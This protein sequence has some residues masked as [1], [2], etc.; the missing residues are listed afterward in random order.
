MMEASIL[1]LQQNHWVITFRCLIYTNL[2]DPSNF[3]DSIEDD[4][5]D[6]KTRVVLMKINCLLCQVVYLISFR[7]KFPQALLT[8]REVYNFKIKTIAYLIVL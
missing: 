5:L 4:D 3:L 2:L 6:I 1:P 7:L 8:S